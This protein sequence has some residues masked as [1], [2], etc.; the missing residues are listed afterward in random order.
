MMHVWIDPGHDTESAA[1]LEAALAPLRVHAPS[2]CAQLL[3]CLNTSSGTSIADL[4][5]I[6]ATAMD[7]G[8]TMASDVLLSLLQS[9]GAIGSL[10]FGSADRAEAVLTL[11]S[12]QPDL[13]PTMDLTIEETL[14]YRLSRFATLRREGSRLII[15]RPLSGYRAAIRTDTVT[16]AKLIALFTEGTTVAGL[17][18]GRI[19]TAQRAPI[20]AMLAQAGIIAPQDENGLLPEDK[21]D[22]LRQWQPQDLAFHAHSRMGFANDPIGATFSFKDEIYAQPALHPEPDNLGR[23][24]LLAPELSMLAATDISLTQAVERRSSR[25]PQLRRALTLAELGI[26][27]FRTARIRSHF[28]TDIGSFTSRPY[29]SGG[30]AYESEI[31]ITAQNIAGLRPGFYYYAAATHELL[32]LRE[33]DDDCASLAQDA[34]TAMAMTSAPDAVLTFG[35]RFQ[36]MQWKYAGMAYATQ[37][38]TTGAAYMAFY[39]AATAMGL[40][41]CGLGLGNAATFARLTGQDPHFE[42]SIGEFALSGPGDA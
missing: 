3:E 23:V 7:G 42:G 37:L 33:W 16:G 8:E 4:Q 20:C 10:R 41:P 17:A 13:L 14:T 2:T 28:E 34:L 27:L 5:A 31:Y 36:R 30:G 12:M 11:W 18:Q 15:E 29:P 35:S 32:L 38:K 39:L 6:T 40:S 1:L 26:F 19:P 21:D 24:P 25:R 22:T 9:L